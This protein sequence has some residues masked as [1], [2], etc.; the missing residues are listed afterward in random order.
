M[1]WRPLLCKILQERSRPQ[2]AYDVPDFPCPKFKT[3]DKISNNEIEKK[4]E[5]R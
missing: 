1:Q 4:G 3:P 5:R 2:G